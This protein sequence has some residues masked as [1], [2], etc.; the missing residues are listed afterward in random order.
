VAA[1]Q[2]WEGRV[3]MNEETTNCLQ[4]RAFMAPIYPVIVPTAAIAM[5]AP[6]LLEFYERYQGRHDALYLPV[7]SAPDQPHPP[8]RNSSPVATTCVEWSVSGTNVSAAVST[9]SLT[10]TTLVL[11]SDSNPA[12]VTRLRHAGLTVDVSAFHGS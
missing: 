3:Q 10:E 8:E 4:V 11:P 5:L 12:V 7:S 1:G 9:M 2:K 6:S